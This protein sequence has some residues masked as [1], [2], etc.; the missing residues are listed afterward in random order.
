MAA[1]SK[2]AGLFAATTKGENTAR[3]NYHRID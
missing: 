2:T 3:R 1:R